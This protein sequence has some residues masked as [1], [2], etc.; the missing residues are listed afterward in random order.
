MADWPSWIGSRL[1][2][3]VLGW[4]H[5]VMQLQGTHVARGKCD[6]Q[7]QRSAMAIQAVLQMVR[8]RVPACML[9]TCRCCRC[10]Y[11][12][13]CPVQRA[14]QGEGRASRERIEVDGRQ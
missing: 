2:L 3:R 14:R 11:L 12:Q 10:C 8:A 1:A 9:L 13:W 6:V 5:G 7:Q 4:L